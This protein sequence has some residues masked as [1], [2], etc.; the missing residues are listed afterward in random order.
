M[1]S[2]NLRPKGHFPPSPKNLAPV[3]RK[4]KVKESTASSTKGKM[5]RRGPGKNLMPLLACL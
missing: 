2:G 1:G 4:G 5:P 3:K